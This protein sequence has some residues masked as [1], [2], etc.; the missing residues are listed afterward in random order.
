M[1]LLIGQYCMPGV[2]EYAFGPDARYIR[3][4]P[5][6]GDI[7]RN[8]PIEI[9]IVSDE[10]ARW[11][12][13][14][15]KALPCATTHGW[16]K[17]PLRAPSS[18]PKTTPCTS[19]AAGYTDAVHPAVIAKTLS[20]FLYKGNLPKD[21]VLVGSGGFG[22]AR[23]TRRWL[24]AFRPAQIMN[25]HYQFGTVGADVGYAVGSGIAVGR[26][27]RAGRRY[28]GHP[29]ITIMG[30]AAFGYSGMEMETLAKH[31]I[32]AII[33]VYNN[34]AWGTWY[35]QEDEPKVVQMHLFQE[36]IRYDKMAESPGRAWHLRD[37]PEGFP[38]RLA[39]GL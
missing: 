36:N 35:L 23:Y 30:D 1:V 11:K 3:I 12:P 10:K 31:R 14:S 37:A 18:K 28:K 2:G 33:I 13:C 5:D 39:E 38:A 26:S 17:W 25:G 7:G 32:P 20:D 8:L 16:R 9:G 15:R 29:T 22:I 21:R 34:N 27:R 6:A 24:R 19:T 4:D